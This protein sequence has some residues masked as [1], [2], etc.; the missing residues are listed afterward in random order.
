MP[1]GQGV[2]A[3]VPGL[4][5][6]DAGQEA[7]GGMVK[8]GSQLNEARMD[9]NLDALRRDLGCFERAKLDAVEIHPHGLDVIKNGHVDKKRMK[10]VKS[11]S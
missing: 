9:G 4:E 1:G 3:A 8:I 6:M 2:A 10:E 11:I 7:F 5:K